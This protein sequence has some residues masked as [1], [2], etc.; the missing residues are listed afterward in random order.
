VSERPQVVSRAFALGVDFEEVYIV[1]GEATQ[2]IMGGLRPDHYDLIESKVQ[3]VR[4]ALLDLGCPYDLVQRFERATSPIH[5]AGDPLIGGLESL[6]EATFETERELDAMMGEIRVYLPADDALLYDLGIMLA[7]LHLC[8]RVVAM[9]APGGEAVDAEWEETY[10]RELARVVSATRCGVA[11]MEA[12]NVLD[13][14]MSEQLAELVRRLAEEFARWDGG[15]NTWCR[16]T[17]TRLDRVFGAA[18]TVLR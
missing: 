13:R 11:T 2:I 9:T 16:T 1:F 12:R 6:L 7:R 17:R 14:V 8:L 10:R 3:R 5:R 18:G 4:D 15:S